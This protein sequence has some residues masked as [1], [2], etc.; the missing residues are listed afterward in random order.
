MCRKNSVNFPRRQ[1]LQDFLNGDMGA[2]DHGPPSRISCNKTISHSVF[3]PVNAL[4]VSTRGRH[5]GTWLYGSFPFLAAK[6]L[7]EGPVAKGA[8]QDI[9][10]GGRIPQV[11]ACGRDVPAIEF[12]GAGRK[13]IL[14]TQEVLYERLHGGVKLLLVAK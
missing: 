1:V 4:L 8:R 14:L 9:P 10:H 12:L 11:T 2:R 7:P 13:G 5:L 6:G 3:L